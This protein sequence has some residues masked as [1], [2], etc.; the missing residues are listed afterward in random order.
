MWKSDR[1]VPARQNRRVNPIRCRPQVSCWNRV[2]SIN[3]RV[4]EVYSY[5]YMYRY[6]I[7]NININIYICIIQALLLGVGGVV[8]CRSLSWCTPVRRMAA[9]GGGSP[10]W[11]YMDFLKMNRFLYK[12]GR[13][14]NRS[15]GWMGVPCGC[16]RARKGTNPRNL[17]APS[18]YPRRS[19][20]AQK[21]VLYNR[22]LDV[23]SIQRSRYY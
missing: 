9:I 20:R 21:G 1:A 4:F 10:W 13:D 2:R 5:I 14:V 7:Y 23:T 19:N 15:H 12:L 8:Q 16:L 17:F 18:R 11:T 3:F 22:R 6:I